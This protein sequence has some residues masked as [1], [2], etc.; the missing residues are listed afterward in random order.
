MQHY[1]T[2]THGDGPGPFALSEKLYIRCAFFYTKMPNG[3][4]SPFETE[5]LHGK[6]LMLW[7]YVRVAT[8]PSRAPCPSLSPCQVV[9]AWL[10]A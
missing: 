10:H 2:E 9:I 4:S 6:L 8:L 7:K 3:S 5:T 1:V